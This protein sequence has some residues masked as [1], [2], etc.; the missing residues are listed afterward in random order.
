VGVQFQ[1]PLY[2]SVLDHIRSHFDL[3]H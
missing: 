2:P 3:R 1:I